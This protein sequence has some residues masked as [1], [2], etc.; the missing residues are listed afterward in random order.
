[1]NVIEAVRRP[2]LSLKSSSSIE[3]YPRPGNLIISVFAHA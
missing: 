2:G 3:L 1:M